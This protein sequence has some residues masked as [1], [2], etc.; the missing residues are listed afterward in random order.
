VR[1]RILG[2]AAGGGFP[3]WN[4]ACPNCR[5]VR[6][7]SIHARFRT[8]ASVALSDDG[9]HWYL[10]GA[11]PEIRSQLESFPALRPRAARHTPIEAI[12]L[13]N[14][15][16]DHTLGLLSLREWSRITVY[17]TE[18]VRDAF[19]SGNV[20]NRALQRFEGHSRW[21]TLAP[22][23][24]LE[25]AGGLRV[26]PI[27]VSGKPPLYAPQGTRGE[28]WTIGLKFTG[29]T[30]RSVGFFPAV[31]RIDA[32]LAE[33]LE[34]VDLLLFDGTLWSD[35]ELIDLGL[36]NVTG[37]QMAHISVGGAEGSLEQLRRVSIGTRVY[38]H[39]NNTNPML[40][41]DSA[42][43]AAV[44]AAGWIIAEDGQEFEV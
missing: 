23:E 22:G 26:Q 43:A 8:Q 32:A 16:L 13:T 15:D 41:E 17:A 25:L 12:F 14:G 27:E 28:A 37:R 7:G 19:C 33:A 44:R 2:S 39:I 21:L 9:E 24:T 1:V 34:G 11:S 31:A 5:G 4:C 20:L 18:P 6:E 38:I 30:G 36:A 40:R 42:E 35:S 29:H 3:Q 10:L